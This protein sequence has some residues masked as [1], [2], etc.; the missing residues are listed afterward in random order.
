M[1]SCRRYGTFTCAKTIVFQEPQTSAQ[2][3]QE[4][5]SAKARISAGIRRD[6]LAQIKVPNVETISHNETK[7]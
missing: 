3:E 7:I 2:I 6:F 5:R 1:W 4:F